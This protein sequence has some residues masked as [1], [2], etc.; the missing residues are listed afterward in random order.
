MIFA[1]CQA[2]AENVGA[3][4][5]NKK[6]HVGRMSIIILNSLGIGPE[7]ASIEQTLA[8][9]FLPTLFGDEYEKD[10]PRHAL[11][12]LPVKWAG[13]AIPDPT[14]SAQPNYE[15]SILLC[16]HILAAFRGVDIFRSTDHLKVIKEVKAELK[17][18]NA[19]KNEASLKDLA[20]KMSC[21]N[22]RTILRGK[23]TGQWLSVLPSIVNGTELLAKEFRDALLLRYARCPPDLPTQCDGCQQKFSVRHALECKRGGLVISRHNEI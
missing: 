16:S 1:N 18:C 3:P 17:L 7:F 12:S 5:R 13:L 11:A 20:L 14:T 8:R 10:D 15:A 2:C 22:R 23:E 9:T 19:A 21:N 6:E 4:A